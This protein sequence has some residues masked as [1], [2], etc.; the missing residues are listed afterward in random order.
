MK[1]D[2]SVMSTILGRACVCDFA[3]IA[4]AD[5]F[6]KLLENLNLVIKPGDSSQSTLVDYKD[7]K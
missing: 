1:L 7:V 4:E 6:L 2:K 3:N 5:E